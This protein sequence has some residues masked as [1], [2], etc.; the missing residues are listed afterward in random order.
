M[1]Q[2]LT[3]FNKKTKPLL[4]TSSDELSTEADMLSFEELSLLL[5]PFL[6]FSSQECDL[7]W[8]PLWVDSLSSVETL[9]VDLLSF[10]A[11]LLD[12]P[13]LLRIFSRETFSLDLGEPAKTHKQNCCLFHKYSTG[14]HNPLSVFFTFSFL[15]FSKREAQA[16][17]F[18]C[19]IIHHGDF[20][21]CSKV[22]LC[23]F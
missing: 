5:W 20:D 4:F 14:R 23:G 7:D 21:V 17:H 11:L 2:I 3:I 1:L 22:P 15:W 16:L 13:E 10:D 18:L 6:G 9:S 8:L 19:D 12:F